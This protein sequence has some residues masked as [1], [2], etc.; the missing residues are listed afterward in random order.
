M[1]IKKGKHYLEHNDISVINGFIKNL[2]YPFK[3]AV[4]GNWTASGGQ[5]AVYELDT[6]SGDDKKYVIKVSEE[7]FERIAKFNDEFIDYC[8]ELKKKNS[9]ETVSELYLKIE[10]H[11]FIPGETP[12]DILYCIIEKNHLCLGNYKADGLNPRKNDMEIAIRLGA[13]LLRLL[14][15]MGNMKNP[16][17]HRDIKPSNIFFKTKNLADGFCLGDFGIATQ[18]LDGSL[19][20]QIKDLGT[21]QTAS[22]DVFLHDKYHSLFSG[23]KKADMY[24]LAVTMYY[25]LNDRE[26][27]FI[28]RK[29]SEGILDHQYWEDIRKKGCKEPKHGTAELKKIVCKALD[30]YPD[31][32]YKSCAEMLEEL[33]KTEEYINLFVE[34]IGNGETDRFITSSDNAEPDKNPSGVFVPD[35]SDSS[36]LYGEYSNKTLDNRYEMKEVIGKGKKSVVYKAFDN[37]YKRNVAVKIIDKDHIASEK[38]F[39]KHKNIAEV[40]ASLSHP[41]IAKVYSANYGTDP[42]YTVSEYVDGINLK[43]YIEQHGYPDTDFS[44]RIVEKILFALQHA[45]GKDISHGNIKPRNILVLSDGNIKITDFGDSSTAK[46]NDIYSVGAILYELLTGQN[47]LGSKATDAP[48]RPGVINKSIPVGLDQ[49]V[50]RALEKDPGKS[51]LYVTDMLAD[52]YRFQ[53]NPSVSFSPPEKPSPE[54]PRFKTYITPPNNNSAS[55]HT[56]V[57]DIPPVAHKKNYNSP[58]SYP[59]SP[60]KNHTGLIIAIVFAVLT[61]IAMVGIY[62]NASQEDTDDW[63]ID[64]TTTVYTTSV[65]SVEDTTEATYEEEITEAIT[66]TVTEAEDV[67]TLS[68]GRNVIAFKSDETKRY[69]FN[70]DQSGYYVFESECADDLKATLNCDGN[71]YEDDNSGAD[72]D[73]LIVAYLKSD[74]S[75][76]LDVSSASET[77]VFEFIIDVS[78]VS[79]TYSDAVDLFHLY[80]NNGLY[81]N[82]DDATYL[83]QSYSSEDMFWTN[84]KIYY[85]KEFTVSNDILWLAFSANNDEMGDHMVYFPTKL[86]EQYLTGYEIFLDYKANGIYLDNTQDMYNN[87]PSTSEETSVWDVSKLKY[88]HS[89][90]IRDNRLWL[91]FSMNHKSKG[92]ITV[93]YPLDFSD[94]YIRGYKLFLDYKE[95]GIY[96]DNSQSMYNNNPSYSEE[97]SVWNKSGTKHPYSYVIKDNILWLAFNMDHNTKGEITVWY[98]IEL[99]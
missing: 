60:R 91:A 3:D 5:C 74:S 1:I 58:D 99:S 44:V 23:A 66:E 84:S 94:K 71:I 37:I 85:P 15:V 36:L 63:L 96:L 43:E 13:D 95:N 42:F 51:Y 61:A 70:P 2:E 77:Y 25:Y 35:F 90:V 76:Y 98:P 34:N 97:T 12:E 93:W 52:I 59:H 67:S 29:T 32:R 68:F 9:D 75:V 89:F 41:N 57:N 10:R 64:D 40:I 20:T 56:V 81:M 19:K 24:S 45:H 38:L 33:K 83:S 82:S 49:I 65:Q 7:S 80:E 78:R 55:S 28:D 31:N 50:M 53:K 26:Y 16:F 48:V 86:T 47:L 11:F 69:Y 72:T 22:P 79:K 54:E 30:F 88:P 17:V 62:L 87:Y 6:K 18:L 27:P 39:S 8:K 46:Q 73:F 92:D 4:I 21:V 14:D